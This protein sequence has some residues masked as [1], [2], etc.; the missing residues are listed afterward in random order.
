V[1]VSVKESVELNVDSVV[2][3]VEVESKDNEVSVTEDEELVEK[4][5]HV[6]TL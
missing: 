5:G 1:V 3:S 2:G 4:L 6:A